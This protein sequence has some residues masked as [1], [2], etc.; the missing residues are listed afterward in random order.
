MFWNLIATSQFAYFNGDDF[1]GFVTCQN[2]LRLCNELVSWSSIDWTTTMA[3]PCRFEAAAPLTPSKTPST[4]SVMKPEKSPTTSHPAKY[5]LIERDATKH[6]LSG[7]VFTMLRFLHLIIMP[8]I[9]HVM[10]FQTSI[11]L[12]IQT[13][14]ETC[15]R[16]DETKNTNDLH[17]ID[18]A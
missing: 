12:L 1:A 11:K 13:S 18:S 17:S 14:W 4:P 3:F 16:R 8:S 9:I 6:V 7:S 15:R 10:Q 5:K 2:K